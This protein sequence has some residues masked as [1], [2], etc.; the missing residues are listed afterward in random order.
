MP[1]LPTN[2]GKRFELIKVLSEFVTIFHEFVGVIVFIH[3]ATVAGQGSSVSV[4]D[5][6][7]ITKQVRACFSQVEGFMQCTDAFQI[8]LI[9][10][11][12]TRRGHCV[13]HE[14]ARIL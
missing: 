4:Y 14:L 7:N 10:R 9:W 2:V 6:T 12:Y 1:I 11:C 8:Y 13:G 3:F 5:P